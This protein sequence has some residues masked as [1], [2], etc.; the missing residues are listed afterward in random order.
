L[1]RFSAE[2]RLGNVEAGAD[3]GK[4]VAIIP[5][6][7]CPHG[8]DVG[9]RGKGFQRQP[10]HRHARDP[11]VLLGNAAACANASPAGQDQGDRACHRAESPLCC[12]KERHIGDS[13][14]RCQAERCGAARSMLYRPLWPA[15]L[16]SAWPRY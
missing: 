4:S 1:S 6:D 13:S 2:D 14:G 16:S 15:R 8:L 9:M 7:N 5:V 3:V 11:A 10:H 12:S